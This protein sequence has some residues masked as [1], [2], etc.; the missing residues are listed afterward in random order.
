MIIAS[1]TAGGPQLPLLQLWVQY[2][3]RATPKVCQ[4]MFFSRASLRVDESF[5][6]G[7]CSTTAAGLPS[8]AQTRIPNPSRG[9]T[10]TP[11][12]R[13]S[14]LRFGGDEVERASSTLCL[15]LTDVVA[16]NSTYDE[17]DPLQEIDIVPLQSGALAD[18]EPVAILQ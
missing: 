8:C 6:L 17:G 1:R 2:Q 9:C 15:D 13:P 10:S 14:G 16:D 7:L 18:A 12:A 5:D 4:P 11:R 3:R